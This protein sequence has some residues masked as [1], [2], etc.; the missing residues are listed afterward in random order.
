MSSASRTITANQPSAPTASFTATPTSGTAPLAV[1]FTDTSSGS[2]TSWAWNFGDGATSSSRSPSHTY[3]NTG[4]YSATLTATNALG[5]TSASQTITVSTT[6]VITP[7]DDTQIDASGATEPGSAP[8]FSADGKPVSDGLLKFHVNVGGPITGA[9][10][11]VYCVDPSSSGGTFYAA[12]ETTP[13]WSEGTVT[14]A[15]APAAGASY[16]S[17]GAV[18]T[19]LWYEIDLSN[20]VTANGT[21]T[22]RIENTST[23]GADYATKEGA[24]GFP[25][26]S[27][28]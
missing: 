20:L 26:P 18:K 13:P 7:S 15:T 8:S 1:N 17:L 6:A 19:G 21:Y 27:S 28:W 24:A 4:T 3:S 22:L 12:A 5:S 10:L 14:W 2:P 11:R 25:L 16:G 23:N 9:T